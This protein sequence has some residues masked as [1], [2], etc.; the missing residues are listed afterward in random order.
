MNI[1]DTVQHDYIVYLRKGL[2]CDSG[3]FLRIFMS[4]LVR[5]KIGGKIF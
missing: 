1:T 3:H 2:E 5:V 4:T